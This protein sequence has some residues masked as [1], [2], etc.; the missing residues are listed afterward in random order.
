MKLSFYDREEA[1]IDQIESADYSKVQQDWIEK[2][3]LEQNLVETSTTY[4]DEDEIIVGVRVAQAKFMQLR[5][6]QFCTVTI[7]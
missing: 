1:L 6:F 4:F 7:Q 3:R 5:G 2:W